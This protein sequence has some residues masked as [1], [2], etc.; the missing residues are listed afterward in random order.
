VTDAE[1]Q[2]VDNVLILNIWLGA[3]I[4]LFMDGVDELFLI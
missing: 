2:A 3:F 1:R 4:A